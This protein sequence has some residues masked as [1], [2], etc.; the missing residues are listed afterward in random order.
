MCAIC[1][2]DFNQISTS[3]TVFKKVNIR[4]HVNRPVRA[5]L[6]NAD[7]RTDGMAVMMKLKGAFATMRKRQKNSG[8]APAQ[9]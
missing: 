3:S 2:P 9:S 6:I 7:I 8:T 4:I 1:F 5:A